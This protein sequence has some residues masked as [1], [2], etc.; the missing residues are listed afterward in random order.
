MWA[1]VTS[2]KSAHGPLGELTAGSSETLEQSPRRLKRQMLEGRLHISLPW[3]PSEGGQHAGPHQAQPGRGPLELTHRG[4]GGPGF[5]TLSAAS[6]PSIH[7]LPEWPTPWSLDKGCCCPCLS[8]RP[9][10]QQLFV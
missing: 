6:Q 3:T 4:R 9:I 5:V 10:S 7:H 8:P 2:P 1:P